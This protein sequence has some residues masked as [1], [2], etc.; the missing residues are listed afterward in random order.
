MQA[1]SKEAA[2]DLFYDAFK[3]SPI[4]IV[5]ENMDGQPI[6]VNPAFCSMLGFTEEEMRDKHC[7]DFSPREDADK[8]WALFQQLRA[9]TIDH[10]QMD[11]RYFRCDGSLVW[12]RLSISLFNGRP[13]PLVLAMVEDITE[14]KQ[15]EEALRDS[16]RQFR[17]VFQEAGVGMV[18]VSPEGN[19]LS[20]NPTFCDCLGYTEEELQAMTVQQITHPEDW[21]AFSGKLDEALTQGR[22]FQWVQKRCLHKSGRVVYTES[23]TSVIRNHEGELKFFVAQV[24]DITGRK[25][26]EEALSGMTRKLVEAQDQERARIARELHDD[27]NQRLALL[28]VQLAELKDS[29][30]INQQLVNDLQKRTMEISNDVQALSHQLHSSKLVEYL[31]VTEA[32]KSLCRD[33]GER[34]KMDVKFES[35]VK[36]SLPP[37]IS[38]SLFRVLQEAVHNASKH[39]GV[40]RVRVRLTEQA[41][42]VHL[43]V[44]DSG[45]GFNVEEAL[46]GKGLGLASMRERVRL[47]NGRFIIESKPKGG[48]GIHVFLPLPR[49]GGAGVRAR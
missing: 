2:G 31:G 16:E 40:E 37:D 41:N 48:T 34:Q 4:G 39:S 15:A 8:D 23:S 32:M 28:A 29:P 20:A 36:S 12:G 49:G 43:A 26:T 10:Y 1:G 14:R 42:E 7:V 3:T 11:K 6:F 44:S 46:Q 24:V 13:S 38:L 25:K 9:G 35:D 45:K 27:I 18:I 30:A 22:G 17:N 21:D 5:V 47:L 33:V 19:Y